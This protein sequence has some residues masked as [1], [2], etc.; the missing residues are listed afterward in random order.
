M[1]SSYFSDEEAS[2]KQTYCTLKYNAAASAAT[3]VNSISTRIK[4]IHMPLHVA[5]YMISFMW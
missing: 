1:C 4:T 3:V 2:K 5:D